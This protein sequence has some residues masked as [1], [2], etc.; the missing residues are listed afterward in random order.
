MKKLIT[1]WLFVFFTVFSGAAFAAP[2]NINKATVEE[3]QTITGIG[4]VKAKEIV[5][6][7]KKNG[8]FKKVDDLE[9]V[10]GFGKTVIEKLR[11]QLTV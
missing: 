5:E 2:V 8:P 7:R 1:A 9:N 3:L 6:F 11:P 4:P 10:K